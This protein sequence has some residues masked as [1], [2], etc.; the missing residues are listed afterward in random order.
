M[1][2]FILVIVSL[3]F[4]ISLVFLAKLIKANDTINYLLKSA[5]SERELSRAYN[6]ASD[7]ETTKETLMLLSKHKDFAVR[8]RVSENKSTPESALSELANDSDWRVRM[9]VA[10]NFS[11]PFETL[12][13]MA[14][15][16]SDWRVKKD[17]L[18]NMRQEIPS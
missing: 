15:S 6:N 13:K 4:I 2:E 16:D 9:G 7:P 8:I 1:N 11:T 5:R 12:R 14:N 18:K 3:N 17:A 10:N